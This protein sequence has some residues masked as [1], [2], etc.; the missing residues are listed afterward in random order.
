M[1]VENTLTRIVDSEYDSVVVGLAPS[2]FTYEHLNTAF[3]ILLAKPPK[4]LIATHRAKYI[5]VGSVNQDSSSA[6]NATLS[7]GPGPFVAALETATGTSAEVLGKPTRAFFRTVI[8]SFGEDVTNREGAIAIVGDDVETDLGGGASEIGLW[9]VLGMSLLSP[10][11]ARLTGY[12]QSRLGNI[13]LE[14][15]IGPVSFHQTK[16]T[17]ALPLSCKA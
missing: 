14:M 2:M 13:V 9:R 11:P 10:I 5:R 1:F 15:R 17:I 3:R 16:Y 7:L 12:R 8:E 6:G 4:P